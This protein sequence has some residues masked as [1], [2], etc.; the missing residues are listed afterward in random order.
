MIKFKKVSD[1]VLQNDLYK[2]HQLINK[3][4]QDVSDKLLKVVDTYDIDKL[5]FLLFT[6]LWYEKGAVLSHISQFDD[7]IDYKIISIKEKS[8]NLKTENLKI[9]TTLR[10]DAINLS[11]VKEKRILHINKIIINYILLKEF[12]AEVA[13]S[14]VK[15]E[16]VVP[17][18]KK[19]F[20]SRELVSLLNKTETSEYYLYLYLI[21]DNHIYV[22]PLT[23]KYEKPPLNTDFKIYNLNNFKCLKTII[24]NNI[25][26]LFR[27][28]ILEFSDC[29]SLHML[30]QTSLSSADVKEFITEEAK[31]RN[32]EIIGVK[33]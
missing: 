23:I 3:Y 2:F 10:D 33:H 11:V 17:Y 19:A 24:N 22:K 32:I 26:P 8:K 16:K 31:F 13:I 7:Y 15:F 1:S 20:I 4:G 27:E 9:N 30:A 25:E 6:E 14:D 5:Y 18:T 12:K 21:T 28:Y 29:D